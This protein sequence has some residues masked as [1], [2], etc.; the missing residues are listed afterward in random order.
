VS[1]NGH[2]NHHALESGL[3]ITADQAGNTAYRTLTGTHVG[4]N[5]AM[6]D[7]GTD[8]PPCT[9]LQDQL[10][11]AYHLVL[12]GWE[13]RGAAAWLGLRPERVRSVCPQASAQR[14]A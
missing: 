5:H 13:V 10:R 12:S 9:G 7:T 3:G 2:L 11:V 8:P 4:H 6:P 14:A 1:H